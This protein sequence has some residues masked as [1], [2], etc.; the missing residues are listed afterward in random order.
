MSRV[1]SKKLQLLVEVRAVLDTQMKAVFRSGDVVLTS[2]IVPLNPAIFA[3]TSGWETGFPSEFGAV[4]CS[5][6]RAA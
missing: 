4:M 3:N 2:S 1:E 6:A 5:L